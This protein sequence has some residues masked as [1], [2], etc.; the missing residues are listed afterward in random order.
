MIKQI[1]RKIFQIKSLKLRIFILTTLLIGS[2]S[3]F[4]YEI[5]TKTIEEMFQPQL[6]SNPEATKHFINALGVAAYIE[7]LHNFVD[8]DSFLMKPLLNKMNKDYEKRKILSSRKFSRRC[9]L[10]YDTL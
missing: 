2:L 9:I 8:Y 6:S 1:V 4:Q 5:Q 10:V 3:V 7:R